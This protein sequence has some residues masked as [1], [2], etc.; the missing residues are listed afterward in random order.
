MDTSNTTV[1]TTCGRI[2]QAARGCAGARR[3]CSSCR[4]AGA[5]RHRISFVKLHIGRKL[6]QLL[7]AH[8]Y[9]FLHGNTTH[10]HTK[11]RIMFARLIQ[12][13]V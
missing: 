6:P 10:R 7:A 2:E 1:C 3:Q 9:L 4:Y 13:K 12:G 8:V 5:T 11:R